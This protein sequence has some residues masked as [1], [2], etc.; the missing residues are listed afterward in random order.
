M[1]TTKP[2]IENTLSGWTPPCRARAS[3]GALPAPPDCGTRPVSPVMFQ[4]EHAVSG[5]SHGSLGT[6]NLSLDAMQLSLLNSDFPA[7]S[8]RPLIGWLIVPRLLSLVSCLFSLS[9]SLSL[10]LSVSLSLSRSRRGKET[11]TELGGA[12]LCLSPP[13][14]LSFIPSHVLEDSPLLIEPSLSC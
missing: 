4:M 11:R 2:H 3:S 14:S 10:S 5:P 6:C 1:N 13:S 7:H 12:L 8:L 9:L